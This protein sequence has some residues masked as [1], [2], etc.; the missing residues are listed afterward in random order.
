[1][2]AQFTEKPQIGEGW[3]NGGFLVFE[4][5]VFLYLKGDQ[6]ILEKDVLEQLAAEGQLAAYRHDD[7]WQCMDTVRDVYLLENLWQKGSPPWQVW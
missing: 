5:G 2:V 6:A 4:P 7:F 3:I 1:M